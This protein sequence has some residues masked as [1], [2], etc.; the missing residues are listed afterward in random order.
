MEPNWQWRSSTA[1]K[2]RQQKFPTT[3][4]IKNYVLENARQNL[5]YSEYI[6]TW[7]FWVNCPK[8]PTI[9]KPI[10]YNICL[11]RYKHGRK[12][13]FPMA[14][15]YLIYKVSIRWMSKNRIHFFTLDGSA[16]NLDR[17]LRFNGNLSNLNFYYKVK[18]R[19]YHQNPLFSGAF[20]V[21]T[22]FPILSLILNL[23]SDLL[24]E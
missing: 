16:E 2:Y 4:K 1:Y 20:V 7:V 15:S 22:T 11:V 5:W 10:F 23:K 14:I 17:K 21:F 24:Q 18:I 13:L 19:G 8:Q 6:T 9:R 3:D 12:T